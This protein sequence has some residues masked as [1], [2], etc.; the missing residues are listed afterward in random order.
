[1]GTDPLR[2]PIDPVSDRLGYLR[3][4]V[5]LT[6]ALTFF[7]RTRKGRSQLVNILLG[8]NRILRQQH[9]SF[10]PPK[11]LALP[12]RGLMR[13]FMHRFEPQSLVPK[14][15]EPFTNGMVDSLASLANGSHLG[16][17]G[18]LDHSSIAGKTWT[19]AI[20]VSTSA[21]FRKAEMFQSNAE[22]FF[23]TWSLV[24]WYIYGSLSS[25]PT[26][27][28]LVSFKEGDYLVLAPPP[29]KSDQFNSAW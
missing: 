13:K 16:P 7:M 3:E 29:S 8:A 10:I 12:L 11:A 1:M 17:L 21:G 27:E 23:F 19:A 9:L 5:L 26:D 20:A 6:N 22:T 18:P 24:S 28:Q 14:R 25:Q 15:R 2:S 4:I